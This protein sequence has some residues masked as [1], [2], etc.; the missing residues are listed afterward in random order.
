[1][2]SIA[3]VHRK[4]AKRSPR[5]RSVDARGTANSTFGQASARGRKRWMKRPG[6]HDIAG[7]DTVGRGRIEVT[8]NLRPS[9]AR[10]R[11]RTGSKRL[12]MTTIGL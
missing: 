11:R 7:V 1:M 9:K 10:G 3:A 8:V 2:P 6:K 5:A 12:N 4:Q